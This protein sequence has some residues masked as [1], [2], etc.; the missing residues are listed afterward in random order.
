MSEDIGLS[1]NNAIQIGDEGDTNPTPIIENPVNELGNMQEPSTPPGVEP[2]INPDE[3]LD[4]NYMQEPTISDPDT[5]FA[6]TEILEQYI[7]EVASYLSTK[8]FM[9]V[10]PD[11]LNPE[12][13]SLDALTETL[14]FNLRAKEQ[15]HFEKGMQAEQSRLQQKLSPLALQLIDYNVNNPNAPEDDIKQYVQT[16]INAENI[17]ALDPN[18]D[19]ETIVKE[20]YKSNDWKAEEIQEKIKTLKGIEG[21]LEK[22]AVTVKPKLDEKAQGIVRTKN[23]QLAQIR[24]F[25]ADLQVDLQERTMSILKGGKLEGMPI[26]REDAN[27]LY[28]AIMN[29]EVPVRMK[30]SEVE[31]GYAEALV[32]QAKYSKEPDA[33][34]NLM[35]GLMV[36]QNGPDAVKNFLGKQVRTEE[37]NK[38]IKER[39]FATKKSRT[40][41]QVP[42][43]VQGVDT[44]IK[45]NM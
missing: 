7:P 35:L 18:V 11:H 32:R 34:P 13:F 25:E 1:F 30:G 12:E 42:K 17:T 27:F 33:L 23:E 39:K 20:Y 21:A 5:S 36:I 22:E 43:S 31:M 37:T 6:E 8:G 41:V 15:Q 40:N 44:G 9:E 3:P 14:E 24:Q 38:F 4:P 26:T 2:G 28:S 29:D 16:L 45:F 10:I 19:A